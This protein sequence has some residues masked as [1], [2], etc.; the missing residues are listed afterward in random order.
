MCRWRNKD[1]LRWAGGLRLVNAT[2][3]GRLHNFD[4]KVYTAQRAVTTSEQASHM[5]INREQEHI[6]R[7]YNHAQFRC[8][9][10]GC[11]YRLVLP[12]ATLSSC[13]STASLALASMLGAEISMSLQADYLSSGSVDTRQKLLSE[14]ESLSRSCL[15]GPD[16]QLS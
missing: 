13:P 9:W 11:P 6:V 3:P 16:L 8:P 7:I 5:Y 12:W 2:D 4:T 1:A 10:P 15:L 14:R